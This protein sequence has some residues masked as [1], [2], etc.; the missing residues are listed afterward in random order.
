MALIDVNGSQVNV[1]EMNTGG[2][3]PVIMIHGMYTNLSVFYFYIAPVLAHAHHVVLYDLRSHGMSEKRTEGYTLEILSND[4]LDLMAT[5]HI[6][7]AHLVGYSYGGTIALYTA[8][9]CPDKVKQIALIEAPSLQETSVGKADDILLRFLP[10]TIKDYTK[11][12]GIPVTQSRADKFDEQRRLLASAD[13]LHKAVQTDQYYFD[14]AA[15]AELRAQTLLLYGTQS[16]LI[17]TGHLFASRIPKAQLQLAE[18]DH[19][20]P[21]QQADFVAREL[22]RFL[23]ADNDTASGEDGYNGDSR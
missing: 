10:E 19:N 22:E 23:M 16:E 3:D 20:L 1:V 17:E 4:L 13:L 5:L 8:L 7:Q 18:G 15:L 2:G 14:A 12:T 6:P 21:V 9:T 11:S